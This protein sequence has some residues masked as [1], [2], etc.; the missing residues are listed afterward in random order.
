MFMLLMLFAFN[1]L[2]PLL[3]HGRGEGTRNKDCLPCGTD[4][5]IYTILK[6][7]TISISRL[8]Q[9]SFT[10]MQ[11]H[12]CTESIIAQTAQQCSD[13]HSLD[14][15]KLDSSFSGKHQAQDPQPGC[16]ESWNRIT[17]SPKLEENS[18]IT[19]S[20]HPPT[21]NTTH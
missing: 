8:P 16:I 4:F 12:R 3:L 19:Q 6:I 7:L 13:Y 14:G 1:P 20:N 5:L 9:F 18:K 11:L 17:E 10:L 2:Y 21:I 15:Y